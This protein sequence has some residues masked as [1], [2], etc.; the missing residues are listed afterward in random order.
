ME[1]KVIVTK[2][3]GTVGA[4]TL[5]LKEI[6][7]T[8]VLASFDETVVAFVGLVSLIGA[9]ALAPDYFDYIVNEL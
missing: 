5:G 7:S 2:T 1:V 8:D 6:L 9:G 4:G 3:V